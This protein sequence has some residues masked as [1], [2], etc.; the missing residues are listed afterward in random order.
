MPVVSYAVLHQSTRKWGKEEIER[1]RDRER[2]LRAANPK[3]FLDLNLAVHITSQTSVKR[4]S[5]IWWAILTNFRFAKSSRRKFRGMH[6]SCGLQ[7]GPGPFANNA[8]R[9][10]GLQNLPVTNGTV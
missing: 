8:L 4:A 7:P 2:R 5:R 6:S 9:I 10:F 3:S 1:G